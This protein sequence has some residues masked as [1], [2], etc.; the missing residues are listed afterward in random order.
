MTMSGRRGVRSRRLG[1][2]GIWAYVGQILQ[3]NNTQLKVS[4]KFYKVV[5]LLVLLH[6]SETWNLSTT[7][8]IAWLEGFHIQA[9]YHMA[10]KHKPW[11]VP[12]HMWVYPS[13]C[14]V[15]KEYGMHTISHYIESKGIP[16]FGT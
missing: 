16:F 4:T 5:V 15:L 7:A 2:Y 12:N 14:D 10:K 8:L 11:K 9:A 6:S 1:G 13:L 3:A